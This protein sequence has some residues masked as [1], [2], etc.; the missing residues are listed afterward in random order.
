MCV[1]TSVRLTAGRIRLP[2]LA[3]LALLSALTSTARAAEPI[4]IGF[5]MALSGGIATNGKAALLAIQMWAE[6][7]NAKGGL[8]GRPVQLVYYDDQSNPNNVP[9][10]YTKLTEVDKIDVAVSYGTNLTA[11]AM[12]VVMQKHLLMMG[13]FG[14]GVNDRF[15]YDRYF[16]IMPMGPRSGEI[17]PE[18]FFAVAKT[19]TPT[20]RTVAIVGAGAEFGRVNTESAR[21]LAKEMGLEIVYDRS[22]P[23]TTIDFA[24]IVRAVQASKPDLVFLASYPTDTVGIVRSIHEVGLKT[25][26][27]G[28][29]PVGLQFASIKTQLGPL[30]NN[31]LGYELWVPAQSLKFPGIEE[32]IAAYQA[33]ATAQGIDPLG[34]YTPPFVYAAMQVIEQAI[35]KTG[36]VDQGALAATMRGETFP[37]IVG[38]VAFGPNG[39]WRK[40]RVLMVQYRSVIGNGLEPFRGPGPYVILYPPE[41]KTGDVASPFGEQ[42]RAFRRVAANT[43]RLFNFQ[44]LA[45]PVATLLNPGEALTARGFVFF[46]EGQGFPSGRTRNCVPVPHIT[47]TALGRGVNLPGSKWYK[48]TGIGMGMRMFTTLAFG[49]IAACLALGIIGETF[50]S[51]LSR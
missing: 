41:F 12:P 48:A 37:T 39:E 47:P 27:I 35:E 31:M 34:F 23:P 16:Q 25:R 44:W 14:V 9:G 28:G 33:Q 40:P 20:P 15:G 13:L 49:F 45:R 50:W 10:I 26:L 24:P 51:R 3:I 42:D 43:P 22:Y 6:K 17:I 2:I 29:G 36:S 18:A 4:K 32:F 46:Q 30:I 38:D 19:L 8:L 1:P 21:K 5:S 7:V 11:P